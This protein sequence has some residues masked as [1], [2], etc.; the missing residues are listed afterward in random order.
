MN[1]ALITLHRIV[2]YGSVLQAY[3][4]QRIFE[5]ENHSVTVIDY[6]DKRMTLYGMLCRLSQKREVLKNPVVNLVAKMV[7]FPSYVRRYNIFQNFIFSKLHLSKIYH[8]FEELSKEPPL[9]DCYCTGSDQVWNSGWNEKIDKTFFFDFLPPGKPCFSYAAS[10]GKKQLDAN[11]K[12]E[13]KR[14]LKKYFALSVRE[15]NGV[16]ILKDLGFNGEQVLDPT[17]L[18]MDAD[19][20]KIA[21]VRFIR[22]RYIFVYNLNR[23]S[24]IDNAAGQLSKEYDLPIYTVSYCFHEIPIRKGKVFV[25]PKVEDWLSLIANATFV[26][27]DSFHATAFSINF[28]KQFFPFYPHLFC[29][30]LSSILVLT[31]LTW[32]ANPRNIVE[33]SKKNIDYKQSLILLDEAR[34]Q[35]LMYIHK[36]LE[37]AAEKAH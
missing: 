20:R 29:S 10:F 36:A 15:S 12:E 31:G 2:N 27:T 1:I 14:L 18:L 28:R 6:Y 37:Y 8:S 26:L 17:L 13:T 34:A 33:S 9:A 19:W 7:M 32:R 5:K 3:A 35:S 11:E 21:S 16:E 4:T 30:R 23:S 24:E 22:K 25:C